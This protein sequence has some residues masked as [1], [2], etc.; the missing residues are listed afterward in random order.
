MKFDGRKAKIWEVPAAKSGE[1]N[2]LAILDT[3]YKLI[4]YKV[5]AN[6]D[7]RNWDWVRAD[8]L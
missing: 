3:D 4:A 7:L 8:Y 5:V 6:N 2:G 1:S